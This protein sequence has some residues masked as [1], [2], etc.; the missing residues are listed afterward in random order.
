MDAVLLPALRRNLVLFALAFAAAAL[1]FGMV[2]LT[3]PPVSEAA[4]SS[5]A[6]DGL[7]PP[8]TNCE[9]LPT[10]DVNSCTVYR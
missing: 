10:G 7:I 5:V 4:V 9:F 8:A 3:A 2:M 6:D 1:A